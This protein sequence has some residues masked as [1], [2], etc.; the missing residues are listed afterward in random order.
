MKNNENN[1][2]FKNKLALF[3]ARKSA[4]ID[5][6]KKDNSINK[7]IENF[8]SKKSYEINNKKTNLNDSKKNEKKENKDKPK[9]E[10]Q[11]IKESNS[12]INTSNSINNTNKDNAKPKNQETFESIKKND[13]KNS[14]PPKKEDINRV[15]TA[16]NNSS[17]LEKIKKLNQNEEKNKVVQ[18]NNKGPNKPI[19]TG[20]KYNNNNKI[21]ED[22]NKNI[23]SND[24]KVNEDKNKNIHNNDKKINE[25]QNKITH[26]NN[27]NNNNNNHFK[28][29]ENEIL[30]RSKTICL[31]KNTIK[32]M[33]SQK[34]NNPQKSKFLDNIQMFSQNAK[35]KTKPLNQE[36]NKKNEFLTMNYSAPINTD[37]KNESTTNFKDKLKNIENNLKK[38]DNNSNNFQKPKVTIKINNQEKEEKANIL[39]SLKRNSVG[40]DLKTEQKGISDLITKFSNKPIKTNNIEEDKTEKGNNEEIIKAQVPKNMPQVQFKKANTPKNKE[41]NN[42]S[43]DMDIKENDNNSNNLEV[44]ENESE[45]PIIDYINNDKRSK[46][47][48]KIIP[49]NSD[50]NRN[51]IKC[52]VLEQKPINSEL[53]TNSFCVAFF[54]T[55]FPKKN[56][57]IIETSEMLKSDC[58][59]K[60]C[61]LLPGFQPEIIYKYPQKDSKALEINNILA[62]ICFP[63]SIKVCVLDKEDSVFTVKNYRSCFTN[64]VGDRFYSMMYH[65]Y[66]KMS[67]NDFFNIYGSDLFEKLSMEFKSEVK[68]EVNKKNKLI[69]EINSKK[70]FYIPYCLC[71]ISKFPFFSQ[72]EKCLESIMETLK[73]TNIENNELNEII[74]F[75][76]KSIPAPYANTSVF[77]P[78]PN[79]SD[80][81]ELTPCFYQEMPINGDNPILL[82]DNIKV[83]NL[84]LLFR[85]LLF[86]QKIL[87][88][89]EDYDK[90]TQVSLNLI[91]LLYPLTWI[92]IFIPIITEKMLKYLQSFLPFLNGMHKSL[93]QKEIVKNILYK[94]HKDLFIFDIDKNKFEISCNL[95]E[96]KKTDPIKFLN[97]QIPPLPKNVVDIVEP[98]LNV[99]KS[100]YTAH[101]PDNY[102]INYIKSKALFIQVFIELL[103]DYKK[104]LT[105]IDDLP[106][107]NTKE[108]LSKKPEND[109]IFFKELTTTQL[110]QIFMQNA[111]SYLNNKNKNY[112]FDELIELYLS[113]KE[114]DEKSHKTYFLMLNTEFQNNINMHL[115]TIKKNYFIYP[116]HLKLLQ[117]IINKLNIQKGR[118][119]MQ[120]TAYF[121][122]K[123]FKNRHLLNEKGIIK[124]NKRIIDNDINISNENDVN[125]YGYYMTPEEKEEES[126]RRDEKKQ[127]KI[128][129]EDNKINIINDNNNL[130]QTNDN[131]EKKEEK[132]EEEE[133]LSN[134]DKEDI[135][136]NIRETLTRVFKSERVNV[137]KDSSVLLSSIEKIYGVNYFVDIIEQNRLSKE[138]KVISGDSFKILLEVIS[139][140]LLRLKVCERDNIYSIKLIKTSFY[141]KAIVNNLEY[142][143]F[144]KIIEK[145]TKNYKLYNEIHFWDLWIEEELSPI[146][147][148]ILNEFKKIVED[149]DGYHYI[150]NENK[151]LADFKKNYKEEVI[152]ARKCMIKMKLNKSFMLSVIEELFNKYFKDDIEFEEFKKQLVKEIREIK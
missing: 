26:N 125:N 144:E 37:N 96:K 22:K 87:L 95:Y 59:H 35:D 129:F 112:Y 51:D 75:L 106:V 126:L 117:P 33:Q 32:E 39:S 61:S 1:D 43:K 66:V 54:I 104:Y 135:R 31:N 86:E 121:L 91:S 38:N 134:A 50:N 149:K 103:Y 89:S 21:N 90:L 7:I 69:N 139:K 81:I 115:F 79:C 74:T 55:S 123:E 140:L 145:L 48:F 105:F 47:A 14:S 49:Q 152:K 128:I 56:P 63:N 146:D 99:L 88:I 83:S 150:D 73:N 138:V 10:I 97:R 46:S 58:T 64:Q 17:V 6:P 12:K 118:K 100:Y 113:V 28:N 5:F 19:E 114:I 84:V 137:T 130:K 27:N 76:V 141:F 45:T 3:E 101:S 62:S 70:F 40:I 78:V 116:S 71:L 85:L 98:Q 11:K 131:K 9:T 4:K 53:Q 111:L 124:E 122:Q 148:E 120:D 94:S 143:L 132:E 127:K 67:C 52:E 23:I 109:R 107:F 20:N 30:N 80:I 44:K 147:K 8:E 42:S 25:T 13:K 93:Y 133:I 29:N 102:L 142:I 65:I 82:L 68:K 34:N 16:L 77:F 57:K 41:I 92:H 119:L 136:D 151:Q 18:S 110:F 60:E 24:K 15:K 72:M 36:K 2:S 108:F